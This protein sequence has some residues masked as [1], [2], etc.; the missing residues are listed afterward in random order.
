M[1]L[2]LTCDII[3][4][5]CSLELYIHTLNPSAA[6]CNEN[7]ATWSSTIFRGFFWVNYIALILP[8]NGSYIYKYNKNASSGL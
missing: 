5:I 2:L 3:S 4:C 1:K 8:L 6:G 7:V